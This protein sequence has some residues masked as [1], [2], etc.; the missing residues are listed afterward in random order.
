MDPSDYN[1]YIAAHPCIQREWIIIML[2]HNAIKL[3]VRYQPL[4]NW[5]VS[6]TRHTHVGEVCKGYNLLMTFKDKKNHQLT[7]MTTI[8][9]N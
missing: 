6:N 4:T 1:I 7:T 3:V 2:H 9:G 8:S 5:F